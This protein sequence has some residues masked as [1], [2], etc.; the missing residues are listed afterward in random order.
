MEHNS[1]RRRRCGRA[2]VLCAAFAVLAGCGGGTPSARATVGIEEEGARA[3]VPPVVAPGSDEVPAADE[4]APAAA[5]DTAPGSGAVR[6]PFTYWDGD[7]QVT[8][9]LVAESSE[10]QDGAAT[11]DPPPPDSGR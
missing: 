11:S 8:V 3:L 6:V 7:D 1:A 9:Y 10:A 5:V 4:T 2:A